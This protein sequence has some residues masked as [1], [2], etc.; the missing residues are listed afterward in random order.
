MVK[1]TVFKVLN[2][3]IIIKPKTGKFVVYDRHFTF[4]FDIQS[5]VIGFKS[6]KPLHNFG[7]HT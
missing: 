3:N 2:R 6:V 7:I 4:Q 1:L 5:T